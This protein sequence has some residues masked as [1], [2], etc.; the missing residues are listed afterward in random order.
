M[1]LLEFGDFLERSGDSGR[2]LPF[3][4]RPIP[5]Q[6]DSKQHPAERMQFRSVD[7]T[8]QY[9]SRESADC[10]DVY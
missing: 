10:V 9:G 8:S 5:K 6:E 7:L 3:A 4:G 1:L 2:S